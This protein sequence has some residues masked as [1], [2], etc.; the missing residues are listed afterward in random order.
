MNKLMI[1][2]LFLG[3]LLA[4]AVGV[5][6]EGSVPH[7]SL[8]FMMTAG[9]TGGGDKID[10]IQFKNGGSTNVTGGGRASIG[11]GV[12]WQPEDT[13]VIVQATVNY[14]FSGVFADN[15][16]ANFSRIPVELMA[17]YKLNDQWRVG[18]GVRYVFAPSYSYD[19][20]GDY[21]YDVDFK[22]TVGGV[23]EVGYAFTPNVVVGLRYVKEEYEL[24]NFK[25]SKKFDGS[26]VG[27]TG[28]YIF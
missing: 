9:I 28:S 4:A 13:P 11:A 5:Q 12:Q 6:A 14:H 8:R 20:D 17:F 26:H 2:P 1:R 19:V 18:G 24:K 16:S 25:S 22:N 23:V 27:L 21:N 3:T 15:G 7:P 10:E